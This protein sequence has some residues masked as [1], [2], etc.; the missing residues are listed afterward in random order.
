MNRQEATKHVGHAWK[1]AAFS[2]TLTAIVAL[3]GV[4]DLGAWMLV[5]AAIILGAAFGIYRGNRLAAIALVAYWLFN[6]V[7]FTLPNGF[8][9]VPFSLIFGYFYTQG[10]RGT[11]ALHRLNQEDLTNL[12]WPD[13]KGPSAPL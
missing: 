6:F 4:F 5:D 9:G 11:I 10:A 13:D 1:A 12:Y 8:G 2:G 7:T 3:I